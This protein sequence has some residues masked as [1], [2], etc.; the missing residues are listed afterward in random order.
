MTD[1]GV[2]GCIRAFSEDLRLNS[3]GRKQARHIWGKEFQ[4]EGFSAKALRLRLKNS[5]EAPETREKL[6]AGVE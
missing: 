1:L 6:G 4:E 5:K 3:E 2:L